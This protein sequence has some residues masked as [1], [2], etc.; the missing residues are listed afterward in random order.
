MTRTSN[1]VPNKLKYIPCYGHD[2][3]SDTTTLFM[4]S[5][6]HMESNWQIKR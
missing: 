1:V 6:V 3:L 5:Y 2:V 4:T